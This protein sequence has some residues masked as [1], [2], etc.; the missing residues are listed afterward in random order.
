MSFKRIWH[1]NYPLEVPHELQFDETTMP[2]AL[3][4]TSQKFPNNTA[5][6]FLGKKIN[7]DK[8]EKLVNQF[9]KALKAL[10]VKKGDTVAMILPNIPQVV[11]ANYA[12]WKIGAIAALNNPLYTERELQY[13]LDDS[14]ATTVITLDLLLPRVMAIKPN[15]KIRHIIT[16][17]INDYLPF[18]IKQLFPILRKNMYRKIT[19]AP[20]VF[21][22]MDLIT[23]NSKKLI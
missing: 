18:P 11:I 17:H 5:L 20:D 3:T 2:Q 19:P 7:F 14:D 23:P 10:G 1:K 9:A 8:L 12:T 15:T 13:Q 16:C 21:Q 22:F 6:I 4:R